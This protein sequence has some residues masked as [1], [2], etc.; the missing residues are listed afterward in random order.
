MGGADAVVQGECTE[1]E[2]GAGAP[3]SDAGGRGRSGGG[4][5][6][7]DCAGAR[8][9]SR[10]KFLSSRPTQQPGSSQTLVCAGGSSHSEREGPGAPDF[11]PHLVSHCPLR[12]LLKSHGTYYHLGPGNKGLEVGD[13]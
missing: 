12:H 8:R 11:T 5:G 3:R 1:E 4:G 10:R 7:S 9:P 13:L 2:S 6:G